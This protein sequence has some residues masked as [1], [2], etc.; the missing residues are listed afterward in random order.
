ME[1][2]NKILDTALLSELAYLKLE[3]K[4]FENKPYSLDNIEEF[5]NSKDDEGKPLDYGIDDSRK[6]AIINLLGNYTIVDFKNIPTS[7]A[8]LN[9]LQAMLLKDKEGNTTIA[10]RG[11]DE[12]KGTGT[13]F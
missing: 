6:Q 5:F 12:G 9:D 11:T 13:F 2:T 4:Y 8:G 7:F 1:L 10:F 3:N